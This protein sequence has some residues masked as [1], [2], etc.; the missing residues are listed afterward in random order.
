MSHSWVKISSLTP[1]LKHKT[2]S[3]TIHLTSIV[4]SRQQLCVHT[5]VIACRLSLVKDM[6]CSVKLHSRKF[7]TRFAE[8]SM[9]VT[10]RALG[11]SCRQATRCTRARVNQLK[12]DKVGRD[13]PSFVFKRLLPAWSIWTFGLQRGSVVLSRH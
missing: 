11:L 13:G 5:L 2:S 12:D 3:D 10:A 6:C 4:G 8:V 7:Y 1:N 9:W